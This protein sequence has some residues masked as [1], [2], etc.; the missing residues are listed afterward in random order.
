LKT[1]FLLLDK[2]FFSNWFS[3]CCY[4]TPWFLNKLYCITLKFIPKSVN[5]PD[6]Q[7]HCKLNSPTMGIQ[8]FSRNWKS[9]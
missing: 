7:L 9:L 4:C 2:S 1:F 5:L 3:K 8:Q 6:C